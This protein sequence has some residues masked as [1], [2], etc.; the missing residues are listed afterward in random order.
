RARLPAPDRPPARSRAPGGLGPGAPVARLRELVRGG[1]AGDSGAEDRDVD[2]ASRPRRKLRRLRVD[3]RR[4][5]QAHRVEG[6]VDGGGAPGAADEID[7]VSPGDRKGHGREESAFTS[8]YRYS[9]P[10]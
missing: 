7:E 10:S 4:S 6:A 9:S 2:A 8:R 3:R 1:Q 5:E